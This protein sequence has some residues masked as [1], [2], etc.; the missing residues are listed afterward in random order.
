MLARNHITRITLIEMQFQLNCSELCHN[1]WL[2]HF[3]FSKNIR[4]FFV[5]SVATAKNYQFNFQFTQTLERKKKKQKDWKWKKSKSAVQFKIQLKTTAKHRRLTCETK[6]WNNIYFLQVR[7]ER[8]AKRAARER[9]RR[10]GN[11]SVEKLLLR[12]RALFMR[13]NSKELTDSS[14]TSEAFNITID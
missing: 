4:S 2:K 9:T 7:R 11:R 8:T 5:P 3:F 12:C 14:E 1:H 10:V 13:W 6:M